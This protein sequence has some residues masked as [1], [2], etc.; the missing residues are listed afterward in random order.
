MQKYVSFSIFVRYILSDFWPTTH[1]KHKKKK[2]W[3]L[4]DYWSY[5]KVL[6]WA[7][8][9]SSDNAIILKQA[10]MVTDLS[11]KMNA[12]LVML[13]IFCYYRRLRPQLIFDTT[14]SI[15]M[16]KVCRILGTCKQF[17]H[18][19]VQILWYHEIEHKIRRFK[20]YWAISFK[21]LNQRLS[22]F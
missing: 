20:S 6:G 7:R 12:V 5:Q 10:S 22:A 18:K 14:W 15:I 4:K 16:V 1:E 3:F 21:A 2:Q 13:T 19:K 9:I 11:L 8:P 17:C